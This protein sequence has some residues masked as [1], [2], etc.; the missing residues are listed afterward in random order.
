[1]SQIRREIKLKLKTSL[2]QSNHNNWYKI[3]VISV[4]MIIAELDKLNWIGEWVF[5]SGFL[6]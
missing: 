5:M 4:K 2:R 3:R 6:M 1:M